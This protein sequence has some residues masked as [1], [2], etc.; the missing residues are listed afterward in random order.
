MGTLTSLLLRTL[1]DVSV[2]VSNAVA[3]LCMP[4]ASANLTSQH[5]Q[6]SMDKGAWK[7]DVQV[8]FFA[9]YSVSA[10]LTCRQKANATCMP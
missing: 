7:A 10:C 9:L 3:K 2:T 4:H 8:M 1:L 5:M 6:M